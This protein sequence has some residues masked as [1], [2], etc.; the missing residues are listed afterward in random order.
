MLQDQFLLFYGS[1]NKSNQ[2]FHSYNQS[3]HIEQ[4]RLIL[5]K[6][7]PL[8]RVFHI[9]QDEKTELELF[10]NK[11]Q[12]LAGNY[13][14]NLAN[15]TVCRYPTLRERN[16]RKFLD[17]KVFFPWLEKSKLVNWKELSPETF[18]SLWHWEKIFLKFDLNFSELASISESLKL[19]LKFLFKMFNKKFR[20]GQTNFS[21]SRK[22]FKFHIKC[23]RKSCFWLKHVAITFSNQQ[24]SSDY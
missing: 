13:Y 10:E 2:P 18:I 8:K 23:S 9:F 12:T 22:V 5:M 7:K 4:L 15:S 14:S 3:G 16:L 24:S 19:L 21:F 11:F 20:I 6:M 17:W 1:L